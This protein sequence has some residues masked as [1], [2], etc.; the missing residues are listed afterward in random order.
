[1]LPAWQGDI[2][3]PRSGGGFLHVQWAVILAGGGKVV[4]KAPKTILHVHTKRDHVHL[5]RDP[6]PSEKTPAK[7]YARCFCM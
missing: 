4:S 5:E 1:M 6:S 3:V 2:W 7:Q